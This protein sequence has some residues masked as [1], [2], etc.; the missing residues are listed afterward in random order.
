MMF[1]YMAIEPLTGFNIINKFLRVLRI[2]VNVE[3]ELL[4]PFMKIILGRQLNMLFRS[5]QQKDSVIAFE[6]MKEFSEEELVTICFKRG[7]NVE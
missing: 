2:P 1:H 3:S 6:D 4:R 5:L 7:I